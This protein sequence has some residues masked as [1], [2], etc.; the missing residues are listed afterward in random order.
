M[1]VRRSGRDEERPGRSLNVIIVD[2]SEA[3]ARSIANELGRAGFEVR[4]QRVDT[5]Q[6]FEAQLSDDAWDLVLSEHRPPELGAAEVLS[7]VRAHSA[8]LPFIIVSGDMPIDEAVASMRG[9]A[10]DFVYKDR[11][12]RLA[13]AVERE[14]FQAAERRKYVHVDETLQRLTEQ[15]RQAQKMESIGRLAGGVAHDF[16]N[17]LTAIFEYSELL[18]AHLVDD[19]TARADV[20]EIK[21]ASERAARLTQ[22]LLAFSRQQVLEARIVD[23]NDIIRGIEKLLRRLI[24]DEIE[25]MVELDPAS[26]T[27]HVDLG[28]IE[29][30]LM[31]LALNARDAMLSG[32]RL[33]IETHR[34]TFD[35]PHEIQGARID[36]GEYVIT[37]MRDTGMGIAPEVLKRV[38]EPFYTTKEPGRG[39]GLGLSTAYGIVKQ[40]GGWIFVESQV[41]Q[42]TV[43]SIYLPGAPAAS[44]Q[45]EAQ[46][47]PESA[48][49]S[50]PETILVADDEDGVRDLIRRS[51]ERQGYR[52]LTA[53]DGAEAARLFETSQ[54]PIRLLITDVVMPKI[55]GDK[56]SARLTAA[57]PH[58]SVLYVSGYPDL[59]EPNTEVRSGKHKYLRKPFT[60]RVLVET[61]RELLDRPRP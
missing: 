1:A 40:S 21:K 43:F 37:R 44:R 32:G 2:N 53:E 7:I 36:P 48:A 19:E 3:D 52:V 17:L 38:F 35:A 31:N 4:W 56:L 6:A 26:G 46:L 13:P 61:V 25:L 8:N 41:G 51:L 20:E 58:L 24:G 9:G 12:A 16:N 54:Q 59:L 34:R 14:L 29:Q 47:P 15:L 57:D 55:R 23:L 39:T 5:R 30:V 28:Q 45:A 50:G 27:V 10:S 60:P 42:G 11:L 22:Q 18:L 49:A 33:T